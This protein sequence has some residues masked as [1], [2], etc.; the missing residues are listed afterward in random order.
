MINSN[1]GTAWDNSIPVG[2]TWKKSNDLSP[3]GWRVPTFDEIK[4]LLDTVE[5]RNFYTMQKGVFGRKFI[6]KATDNTLFLPIVNFRNYAG[7]LWNGE[8]KFGQCWSSTAN[9]KDGVRYLMFHENAAIY[10]VLNSGRRSG[11]SVRPVI[12]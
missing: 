10:D 6:D 5:V 1:G 8:L 7:E 3:V 9:G 11:Y 2:D 12:E 4:T